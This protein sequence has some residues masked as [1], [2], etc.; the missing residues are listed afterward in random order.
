M[1]QLNRPGLKD[2]RRPRNDLLKS[3]PKIII[4]QCCGHR[5]D[6]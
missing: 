1:I 6:A 3:G 5:E 4:G 2:F